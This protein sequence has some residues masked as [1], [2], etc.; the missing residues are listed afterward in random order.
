MAA[1][2]AGH[3]LLQRV[4]PAGMFESLEAGTRTYMFECPCGHKRDLWEAG[5]IKYEGNEQRSYAKCSVCGNRTW[6]RKRKKNPEEYRESILGARR[7]VVLLS[8]HAWWASV[9]TWGSAAMIWAFPFLLLG[10]ISDQVAIVLVWIVSYAI[11]WTAPY[12]WMTTRYRVGRTELK[13]SAGF[14]TRVLEL[15][16]IELVSRTR[17]SVG[18]SFAFDTDFLWIG[19]PSRFGGYLVSP[20]EKQLFLELLDQKCHHLEMRDGELLPIGEPATQ[21]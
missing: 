16:K 1:Y 10:V 5:G 18:V 8:G 11:G 7:D 9:I 19:Y 2:T 4:V 3:R 13:L 14:L 6:H 12:L 21:Q 20:K 17:Q 15:R